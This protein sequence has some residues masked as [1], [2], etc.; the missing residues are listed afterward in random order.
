MF[1][2]ALWLSTTALVLPAAAFAQSSTPAPATDGYHSEAP[3]EIIVTAPY[4]R[5]QADILSGTSVLSGEALTRE[6]RPTIGETLARQPG[7]SATSFGPNASR[8]VLRGLQGERVRVLTDGIGSFD[9]SNTS[10]DHAVAIN[11]LTA[12]RIEVLR[13]PSALLFGSSAIGGVVNVI[14]SRIPRRV[15]DEPVHVD[16]IATYGSA[17]NERSGSAAV[18]VPV[19]DKIVFHLDGT[20]G[21]TDDLDTGGYILS[22]PLRAQAAASADAGTRELADLR[23]KLPNSQSEMWEVA[24]GAAVVTDTGNLGFSV[25][26]LDNRYGVPIRYSLD[27]GEAEQVTLHVQ[28]T[29]ADMRAEV[30]TGGG[31]LEKIRLRAGFADYRH[32]EIEDTGAIGTSFFN[33]GLEA[34]LELVQAARGG[35]RGAVGGQM[36][37]RDLNIV[38]DEKFLPKS[39]TQQFGLFTLQSFDMGAFRAEA[40]GRYEYTVARAAADDLLGNDNI[41]RSFDS[42]S[43]SLG[44]SVGLAEHLRF[45]INGSHTERAPSAEELFANGPHA[46]TQAFEVGNAGFAKEISDGIEAT[47]KGSGDGYSFGLSAYHNWFRNFIYENPTGTVR[48]DLPVFQYSQA[49]ARLWGFEA[50]ASARVAKFGETAINVDGL[51]DYTRATIVDRGPAPRIPP[52]R[53]LGGIEAQGRMVQVRGEVEHVTRQNRVADL[54]TTTPAYT[55]VNASVS[56]KPF[57][58]G[59]NTSLMLSANNIFDVEARRHAS[60]LKDYAPLAGRDIRVTARL[61]L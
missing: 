41:R 49:D 59:S 1:R 37:I 60:F 26:H 61:A 27:G 32:D 16:A 30:D 5:N 7:V 14:D 13:G 11:P 10:V 55:M 54:E 46:G 31:L 56:L 34:R 39:E 58:K 48:D 33:Q 3:P 8:P 2:P 53:V 24:G 36:F 28:Q 57:G 52:L 50:E 44:G 15:P 29:R 40:G 47:L 12:D 21:K 43:G 42:F 51:A 4:Q 22:R 6:L 17:A 20:Y 25:S 45:G 23:G 18:D 19:T 9:V 38:G 35:W